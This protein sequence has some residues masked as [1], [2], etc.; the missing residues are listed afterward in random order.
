M[1]KIIVLSSSLNPKSRSRI[2]AREGLARLEET[3][4]VEVEYIDLAEAC[5]PPCDGGAA[6]GHEK[7]GAFKKQMMSAQGYLIATPVYNYDVNSTLKNAIELT[8]RDVWTNKVAAFMCAAGGHGSYMSVMAV[9][10]SLM[11]DFRTIIVPRFV[12]ATGGDF[13]DGRV[14]NDEIATRIDGVVADLTRFT[15]ALA[16]KPAE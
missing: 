12:Y 1:S 2:M 14:T 13:E 5:L 10:N 3:E 16:P 11:L 4:G 9:A 7:T 6:Y 15:N 8:G